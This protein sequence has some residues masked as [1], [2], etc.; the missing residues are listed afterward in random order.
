VV[1][2]GKRGSPLTRAQSRPRDAVPAAA[3]PQLSAA[4]Q[5]LEHQLPVAVVRKPASGATS[6]ATEEAKDTFGGW[7]RLTGAIAEP[8]AR[9]VPQGGRGGSRQLAAGR[10]ESRPNTAEPS[11]ANR[12]RS[13]TATRRTP[14]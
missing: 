11:A 6:S 9:N 4:V 5:G 8:A 7:M 1:E 13:S 14:A 12:T 3:L 2:T 10:A